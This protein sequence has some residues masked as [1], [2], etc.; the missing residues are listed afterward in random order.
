MAN[1]FFRSRLGIG[2]QLKMVK[3]DG[4]SITVLSIPKCFDVISADVSSDHELVRLPHRI[5]VKTSHEFLSLV[6]SVFNP[7]VQREFK[8]DKPIDGY[9][10]KNISPVSS[11]LLQT[12]D[13]PHFDHFSTESVL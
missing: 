13:S 11:Q 10:L 1:I 3:P 2:H 4:Q 8:S 7:G 6:V 12:T 5:P 9:F